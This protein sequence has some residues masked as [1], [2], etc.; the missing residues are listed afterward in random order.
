RDR[1][2][3]HNTGGVAPA[4]YAIRLGLDD[5][6]DPAG[7]WRAV[8]DPGCARRI[9]RSHLPVGEW[10]AAGHGA[11]DRTQYRCRAR[12]RVTFYWLTLFAAIGTSMAGQTLLNAGAGAVD[13]FAQLA[14][15]RTLV[16]FGLYGGAAVLYI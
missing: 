8:D 5:D 15:W 7:L 9:C 14:D 2:G 3:G 13:F 10:Q 12:K 16:G 4:R 1:R 6:G 11:F